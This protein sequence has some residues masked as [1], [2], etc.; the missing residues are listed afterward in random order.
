[1]DKNPS[2][3][4]L[5]ATFGAYF[6]GGYAVGAFP[7]LQ[8]FELSFF[9]DPS[10]FHLLGRSLSALMGTASVWLTYRIAQ[11]LGGR[12]AGQISALFL[13]VC[14][15]HVRDSHFATT[16]V[17]ATF[18][19]LASCVLTMRYTQSGA[20][21]DLYLGSALFGL[22]VSTKYNVAFCAVTVLIRAP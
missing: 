17:P 11:I 21:R 16:D 14:F 20:E 13:A 15:L 12:R 3:H 22:G 4:L 6:A 2:H 7:S 19:L 10:P 5:A 1:M 8:D 18:Y 9:L